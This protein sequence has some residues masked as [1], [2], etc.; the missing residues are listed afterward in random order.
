MN[1][2]SHPTKMVAYLPA[3]RKRFSALLRSRVPVASRSLSIRPAGARVSSRVQGTLLLRVNFDRP[4]RY[5]LPEHVRFAPK[6][7]EILRGSEM[8]AMRQL[9][10]FAWL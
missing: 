2:A 6:Q 10:P 4:S 9:R 1:E 5:C 3:F 7:T 8:N